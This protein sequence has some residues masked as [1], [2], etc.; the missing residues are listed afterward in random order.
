MKK[1]LLC[2][3]FLYLSQ[4]HAA[5]IGSAHIF[6]ERI[7]GNACGLS[8]DAADAAIATVLRQNRI[9]VS[10]DK[11]SKIKFYYQI[12]ALDVSSGCAV[13][14]K[15][16][17]ITFGDFLIPSSPPKKLFSKIELCGNTYLLT[18]PKYDLQG[19]VSDSLRTLAE[20][21]INEIGKE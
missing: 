12:N 9:S 2:I 11:F 3:V 16:Q 7:E 6:G 8:N 20:M 5:T 4:A 10:Q 19:R 15:L 17:V 14:V 1:I 18:G 13:N 21:C